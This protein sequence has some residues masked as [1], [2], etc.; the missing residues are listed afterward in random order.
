MLSSF[1]PYYDKGNN[2]VRIRVCYTRKHVDKEGTGGVG[3]VYLNAHIHHVP[4]INAGYSLPKC[5]AETVFLS[6]KPVATS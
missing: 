1:V 5:E 6:K 3:K 2:R 4:P